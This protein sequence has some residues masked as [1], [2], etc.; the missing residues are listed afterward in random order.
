[1]QIPDDC[2][3]QS[4]KDPHIYSTKKGGSES[5]GGSVALRRIALWLNAGFNRRSLRRKGGRRHLAL[6]SSSLMNGVGGED[7]PTS[8][9]SQGPVTVRI[10]QLIF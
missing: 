1:M 6:D 9:L 4:E 8:E 3:Q 2:P 5:E 7:S 10:R